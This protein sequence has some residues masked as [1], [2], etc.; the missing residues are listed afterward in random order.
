V[1]APEK[2]EPEVLYVVRDERGRILEIATTDGQRI[3]CMPVEP[4][5]DPPRINP[6]E[7]R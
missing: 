5:P 6:P 2:G 4:E 3:Y 1:T 7:S